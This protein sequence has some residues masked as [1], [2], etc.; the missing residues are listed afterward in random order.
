M[1]ILYGIYLE[2]S[3]S[4]MGINMNFCPPPPP[5]LLRRHLRE[6]DHAGLQGQADVQVQDVGVPRP[7]QPHLQRDVHLP[8]G[9]VP[10]IGG[11]A[12]GVRV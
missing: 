1:D 12:A 9:P 6:A 10:A 5:T 2:Y 3:E 8:G 4:S 11:D 7:A